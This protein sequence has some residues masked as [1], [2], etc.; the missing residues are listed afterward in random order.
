MKIKEGEKLP[1][2]EFFYLNSEGLQKIKS[3]QLFNNQKVIVIGVPGA[4][5]KVCSAEHLPGY[6]KNFD[7]AK[8]KRDY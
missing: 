7:E 1:L 6:V 4:F 3:T 8:K 5:T 2:T